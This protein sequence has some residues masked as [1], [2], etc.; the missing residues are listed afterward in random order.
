M[1]PLIRSL[2][3]ARR[4]F[5]LTICVTTVSGRVSVITGGIRVRGRLSA[6]PPQTATI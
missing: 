5:R 4:N 3:A 6:N 2:G 1:G